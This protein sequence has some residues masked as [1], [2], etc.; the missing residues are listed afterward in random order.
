MSATRVKLKMAQNKVFKII[1]WIL[2]IVF[3]VASGFFVS[4]VL[5]QFFSRKTSFSQYKEKV[6][7]YPV[8]SIILHRNASEFDP[9]DVKI[10][11]KTSGMTD[12]QYLEI[13]RNN[14]L[15]NN[16][17]KTERVN[18]ENLEN[19][20]KSKGFRI[21]HET[22]VLQMDFATIHIH[23]EYNAENKINSQESDL[24]YI[25][26]TS[27]KNSPGSSFY[28]WKDGKPLKITMNKNTKVTYNIQPQMIKYLEETLFRNK[29]F[30]LNLML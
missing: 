18:L 11:Y 22:S 6:T 9:S 8:V 14:L 26:I 12:F 19:I 1:E 2:F 10:K 20:W 4:G 21:I 25:F 3:I 7:D 5:Q 13:G 15:N 29:R 23:M 30:V 16:F 17:N 27:Q 24:A 28:K